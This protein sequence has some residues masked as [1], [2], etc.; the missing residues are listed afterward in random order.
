MLTPRWLKWLFA[1]IIAVLFITAYVLIDAS[2]VYAWWVGDTDF[3]YV[4][5]PCDLHQHACSV[6]HSD[7]KITYF[8]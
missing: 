4:S 8:L 2:D 1:E 5:T 6:A 3:A 7:T